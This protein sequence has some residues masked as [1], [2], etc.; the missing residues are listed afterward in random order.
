VSDIPIGPEA[1][2]SSQEVPDENAEALRNEA[3]ELREQLAEAEAAKAAGPA[4]ETG[5]RRI[6]SLVAVILIVLGSV[7]APIAGI[8][9]F[10]RNQVLNTDRYVSNIAPLSKNPAIAAVMATEVTNGLFAHLNV[11]NEIKSVL[12]PKAA[13]VA[14]PLTNA[15]KSQTYNITNKVILSDRFNTIWLAM[16][17]AVHKNL[18]G[19]LTG[20]G[21][22]A[23]TADKNGKV[24]LDLQTLTVNVVHQLDGRGI[25]IFDKLPISKLNLQI[26]LL[27]SAGL[28]KAQQVTKALN[29]L[30]LFLPALSF[31]CFAGAIAVSPRRRRAV[32]WDGLGL[33]ASMAVLAI[34]LGLARSYLI[35]ASAGHQLTPE[36]ATAL[37]D[38]LL[39]YVKDGLRIAFAVGLL[40]AL[41]A[42]LCGPARPVVALR[43]GIVRAYRFIERGIRDH[44]WDLGPAGQWVAANKG[45]VQGVLVGLAVLL[46]IWTTP[47][48]GGVLVIVLVTAALVVVVRTMALK[49]RTVAAVVGT[50]EGMGMGD[51]ESGDI[52]AGT[53]T[54]AS[55]ATPNKAPGESEAVHEEPRT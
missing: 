32:M 38:T 17:R 19:V 6:R 14:S 50:G 39:R 54:G 29:H 21:G 33:A 11:E 24:T 53:A 10:I 45:G 26:V 9:V 16:N 23:V 7:L 4:K 35:S 48:I 30:A 41:V 20:T 22:G 1:P 52:P 3:E 34:I 8:T 5:K 49:P 42:W 15:L 27:Q 12:P 51:A 40:V 13:F 36:A 47:G 46:L 18:V 55:T 2:A 37:F 25:T 43:R 44:G 28:V 31:L